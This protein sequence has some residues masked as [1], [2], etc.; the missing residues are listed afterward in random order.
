MSARCDRPVIRTRRNRCHERGGIERMD[1]SRCMVDDGQ[2][3]HSY[4][5]FTAGFGNS[6]RQSMS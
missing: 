4:Q 2:Q 3:L 5:D 6:D 1:D